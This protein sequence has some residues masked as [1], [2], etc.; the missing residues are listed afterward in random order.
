MYSLC[1]SRTQPGALHVVQSPTGLELAM[2]NGFLAFCTFHSVAMRYFNVI[3]DSNRL[4]VVVG[5]LHFRTFMPSQCNNSTLFRLV[6]WPTVL[7]R[8]SL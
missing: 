8:Y 3:E 1:S 5:L 7:G 2:Y 4:G 6:L